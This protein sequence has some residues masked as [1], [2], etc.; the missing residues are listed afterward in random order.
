M[1]EW[2]HQLNVH[3]FGENPN[4]C[5]AIDQTGF[6]QTFMSF[7][8]E[9]PFFSIPACNPGRATVFGGRGLRPPWMGTCL[10]LDDLDR[11]EMHWSGFFLSFLQNPFNLGL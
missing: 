5:T 10:G 3:E 11:S 8:T 4:A 6:C 9:V 2:H 7:P 1:V